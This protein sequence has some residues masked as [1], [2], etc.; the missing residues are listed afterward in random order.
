[1]KE[2]VLENGFLDDKVNDV[3]K[4]IRETNKEYYEIIYLYN[5]LRYKVRNKFVKDVE[6]AEL[7]I[8]TTFIKL[9]DSFQNCV[10]LLERGAIDDYYSIFRTMIDKYIDIVFVI[11]DSNNINIINNSFIKETLTTLNIIN[12][13]K[14]FDIISEKTVNEK[15]S[16]FSKYEESTKYSTL[17]KAK[18]TNLLK[19]Y[20]QFR[21]LSENVHNGFRP[22][23]ENLIIKKD[24]IILDSGFK[25]ENIKENLILLIGFFRDSLKTIISYLNDDSLIKEFDLIETKIEKLIDS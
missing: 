8:I 24:G 3:A 5:L 14:L 25:L 15:I 21:Y 9:H 20:M 11:K 6:F 22:L 1:M 18:A 10:I 16:E 7:F 2:D 12:E 23:Y 4:N 19:E 17:K 13:N